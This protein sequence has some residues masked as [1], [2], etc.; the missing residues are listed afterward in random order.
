[1]SK[2]S[3]QRTVI[4]QT[5]KST[6]THPTA[7]WVYEQVKKIIPRISL[8]TVYR[9]LNLLVQQGQIREVFVTGGASRY[10]GYLNKHYHF[11]C[12]KCNMLFDINEP[13]CNLLEKKVAK[14][15]G[16]KVKDHNI[17]LTGLC[18]KCRKTG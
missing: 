10:D 3:I 6:K 17:E 16:F 12:E 18:L 14:S 2:N 13:V 9:N 8:G 5:V 7:D 4:L 15:T 11:R 1:M